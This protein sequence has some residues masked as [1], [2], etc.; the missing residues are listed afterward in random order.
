MRRVTFA[1]KHDWRDKMRSVGFD[2]HGFP[3]DY[4]TENAAWEFTGD[5]IEQVAAATDEIWS[6]CKK[7]VDHIVSNKIMDRLGIPPVLWQHISESWEKQEPSLYGRFDFR[8]DGVNPPK[9]YEFNADTPVSLIESAVAQ[10]NWLGEYIPEGATQ[11]CL[12]HENLIRRWSEILP[13]SSLVHLTFHGDSNEDM[14]TA[15]YLADTA[16]QA[17]LKTILIDIKDIGWNATASEFRDLNEQKITTCFKLYPWHW[18]TNEAFGEHIFQPNVRWLEPP[19]KILLNSKGILPVLWELFPDHP[20][21]L[22]AYTGAHKFEGRPYAAKPMFS[23][24]G[25]SVTLYRNDGSV[26]E[27][28]EADKKAAAIYQD[29][30]P[31]PLIDGY[32]P[33]IGSW[34]VGDVASGI[35]I[36]E[37]KGDNLIT[38]YLSRFISHF[39]RI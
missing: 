8:Y 28:S 18:L 1:E 35:G 13:P 14:C 11:F 37:N 20:N 6:M 39:Y 34:L 9:L 29:Y 2:Y 27:K 10:W 22:A 31:L 23:W 30:C 21:L 17:G 25:D 15:R 24:G 16:V 26:I 38:T 19:W 7:A 12:V 3:N 32:R 4:W 36:R 33:M 5:Q